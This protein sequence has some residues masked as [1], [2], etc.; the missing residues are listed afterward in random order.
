MSSTK[1]CTCKLRVRISGESEVAQGLND[2]PTIGT[3]CVAAFVG[4]VEGSERTKKAFGVQE[5]NRF[6]D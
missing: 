1:D 6:G 4:D 2:E 3:D 5:S